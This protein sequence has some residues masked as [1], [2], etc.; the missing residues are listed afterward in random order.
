MM[1]YI[2]GDLCTIVSEYRLIMDLTDKLVCQLIMHAA[3]NVAYFIFPEDQQC[4][5]KL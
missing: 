5:V 3:S 2:S 4:V 1:Q